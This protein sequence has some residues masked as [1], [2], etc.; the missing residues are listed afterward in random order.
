MSGIQTKFVIDTNV[1]FMGINNRERKSGKILD[2]ATE[3]KIDLFAPISVREELQRLLKK[4]FYWLSNDKVEF[5]T[6]SLPITWIEKEIYDSKISETKVKH[7]ADK[8]IE[9]LALVL[10]CQILS[11]D[12]HFK[13]IEQKIDIDDL[14]AELEKG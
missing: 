7:K 1:L 10:N 12:E 13:N 14:L 8:P 5:I 9:A 6:E 4:K 11:A 3:N 2:A